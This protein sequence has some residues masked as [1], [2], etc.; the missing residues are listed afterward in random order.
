MESQPDEVRASI[1]SI[2][3]SIKP[4]Q[5]GFDELADDAP[6]FSDGSG[7]PSPVSLDSL[8]VLDLAMLIGDEFGLDNEEFERLVESDEGLERLRTVNDITDLVLAVTQNGGGA[9]ESASRI[10]LRGKEVSP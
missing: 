1:R 8:D 5:E 4:L 9:T 6:L 3:V 10:N 7:Q 2:I